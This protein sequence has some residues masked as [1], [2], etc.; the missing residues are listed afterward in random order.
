MPAQYSQKLTQL[1]NTE[2]SK[3]EGQN[4]SE[5]MYMAIRPFLVQLSQQRPKS[6]ESKENSSGGYLD[7]II[8]PVDKV[9]KEFSDPYFGDS[10]V[11]AKEYVK[12]L[13][14]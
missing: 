12:N 6:G 9:I 3:M 14:K 4:E 5:G 2:A 10:Y 7:F 8:D 13:L 1:I 11:K